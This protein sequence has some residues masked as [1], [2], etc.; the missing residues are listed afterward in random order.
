MQITPVIENLGR[1]AAQ[2]ELEACKLSPFS[3]QRAYLASMADR[4][5]EAQFVEL[6]KLEGSHDSPTGN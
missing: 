4:Y 6:R 3:S 5:R 1:L 2:C